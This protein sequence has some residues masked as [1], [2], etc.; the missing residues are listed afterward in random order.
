MGSTP[1]VRNPGLWVRDLAI[2]PWAEETLLGIGIAERV[3]YDAGKLSFFNLR[4]VHLAMT[5]IAC[6][7]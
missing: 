2:R 5:S 7:A 1:I 4:Y 6:D 3:S